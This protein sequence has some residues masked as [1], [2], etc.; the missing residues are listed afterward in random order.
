MTKTVYLI[1]LVVVALVLFRVARL[2]VLKKK[3]T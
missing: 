3:S 2:L 1:G